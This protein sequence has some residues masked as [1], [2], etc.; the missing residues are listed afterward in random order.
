MTKKEN[1]NLKKIEEERELKKKR[2]T[3]N[4]ENNR[5]TLHILVIKR[6]PL[7]LHSISLIPISFLSDKTGLTQNTFQYVKHIK[8]VDISAI[9]FRKTNFLSIRAFELQNWHR[10]EFIFIVKT[11]DHVGAVYLLFAPHLLLTESW[12]NVYIQHFAFSLMIR[13]VWFLP[14][15]KSSILLGLC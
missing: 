7:Y 11:K 15:S 4:S 13:V 3:N 8:S 2:R 9:I 14:S 10:V 6:T 5:N 12:Q 1:N